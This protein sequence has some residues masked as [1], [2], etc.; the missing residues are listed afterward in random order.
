[1][2]KNSLG[3]EG[4]EWEGVKEDVPEGELVGKDTL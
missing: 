2:K 1:M 3:A 4:C